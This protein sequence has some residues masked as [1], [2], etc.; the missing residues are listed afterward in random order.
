MFEFGFFLDGLYDMEQQMELCDALIEAGCDYPEVTSLHDRVLLEFQSDATDHRRAILNEV[1]KI[2]STGARVARMLAD[3]AVSIS[4]I[5]RR[6]GINK[7]MVSRQCRQ[8]NGYEDFPIPAYCDAW[9]WAEV[10]EWLHTRNHLDAEVVEQARALRD[11]EQA[12]LLRNLTEN[13]A[14]LEIARKIGWKLAG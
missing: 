10:S 6:S 1:Q 7:M 13:S 11:A 2:E 3:D 4:E 8:L 5:A 9:S 14:A 12:L